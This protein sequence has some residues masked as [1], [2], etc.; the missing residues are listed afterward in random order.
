MKKKI[1][2]FASAATTLLL[3][4]P[5]H[6]DEANNVLEPDD[7]GPY[8]IGYYKV[9]YSDSA[10]GCFIATIRYLAKYNGFLAPKDISG[11]PY[12]DIVVA[13]GFAGSYVRFR[14]SQILSTM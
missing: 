5:I 13:N 10:Y 1:I 4:F 12:P 6:A 2:L 9:R 11:D 3:A 7:P 8:H 14:Q